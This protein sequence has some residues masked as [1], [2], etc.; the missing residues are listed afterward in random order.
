MGESCESQGFAHIH[1]FR[2][3]DFMT[4]QG[5]LGRIWRGPICRCERLKRKLDAMTIDQTHARL[6]LVEYRSRNDVYLQD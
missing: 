6:P 4:K 2:P 3:V 5:I 1:N